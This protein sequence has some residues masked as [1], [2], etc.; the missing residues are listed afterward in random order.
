MSSSEL[1][2]AFQLTT[3]REGAESVAG[4]V[5][6]VLAER[7]ALVDA[8][9]R[10]GARSERALA[11]A[12]ILRMLVERARRS[13][14][15]GG[16]RS[17]I[18]VASELANIL[19]FEGPPSAFVKALTPFHVELLRPQAEFD[20]ALVEVL[21]LVLDGAPQGDGA[22]VRARLESLASPTAWSVKSHRRNVPG[23]AVELMKK[24][25]LKVAEGSVAP[26]LERQ[27]RWNEAAIDVLVER[28]RTGKIGSL[29][30]LRSFEAPLP[31]ADASVWDGV[32]QGQ[33]RFNAHVAT[34]LGDA[35]SSEAPAYGEWLRRRR[36]ARRVALAGVSDG[37]PF[38]VV[39]LGGDD[40]R[41]TA[42]LRAQLYPRW[43]AGAEQGDWLVFVEAG[44]TLDELALAELAAGPCRT[45]A[46]V[47]Y[48]DEDVGGARPFFKPDFSYELLLARDYT[49]RLLAVRRDA[50]ERAG[51]IEGGPYALALR[52]AELGMRFHHVA[53]VLCSRSPERVPGP[54]TAA[55]EEHLRR[56]GVKAFVE[57]RGAGH[58]VR[59]AVPSEPMVS[60]I[61]PFRDRPEL[62]EMLTRTLFA[63][64]RYR[65][66]ELLLVSN[67]SREPKTRE[68]LDR[69]DDPRVVKLE[70]N[71]PFHYPR[72]NNWAAKRAKGELLLFLNNDI[73]ITDP[74]WLTTLVGHA[75]QPGVGAVAPK[76]L[77]PDGTIQHAGV[78][79]GMTGFAGHVF[80]AQPD[81]GRET[82]FGSA[83]HARDCLAVTSAAVLLRRSLFDE[84]E[85]FD[86]RFTVC[87]GDVDLCLRAH[88]RGVRTVYQPAAVLV[89]HESV[90]RRGSKIPEDDFWESFRSYAPY[91][92]RDPFYSPHLG[93][94][95]TAPQLRADDTPAALDLALET[96]AGFEL[97]RGTR[98][99]GGR[100]TWARWGQDMVRK[101]DLSEEQ[102][103]AAG[104]HQ[105]LAH[106]PKSVTWLLPYFDHAFGGVHTILRFADV[107]RRKHGVENHFVIFDYP[108]VTPR[109]M[110]AKIRGLFDPLPGRFSILKSLNDI[111][112]LDACDVSIATLWSSAFYV[113]RHQQAR[114]RA[115]FVQDHEAQ[116]YPAGSMSGLAEQSYRLGL[117]GLF[118][119]R[120]L[121]EHVTAT[122]GMEGTWFDPTV[123]HALFHARGRT[124]GQAPLRLFFYGRP[125]ID[126]NAFELGLE[127]LRAVKQRLG[128]RVQI[129][130]AGE[131]WKPEWFDAEGIVENLGVLPYRQT[132][133]LY[134][135]ID[136]GLCFMFTRHPSYLPL[137][138]M[139]SGVAV[140]TNDNAAN[141][142]LLEHEQNCLLAPP[143]ASAV[144]QQV[145][146]ALVDRALR[147]RLGAAAAQR[148][149]TGDWEAEASKTYEALAR[150]CCTFVLTSVR[151]SGTDP[152]C[153]SAH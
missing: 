138:L 50:L 46:E 51:G 42:S 2:H 44:D 28:A 86:E 73:E 67:Q 43:K 16:A 122:Y 35:R 40:A 88:E 45:G 106:P 97:T 10:F 87:G 116:F 78:V 53:E 137:E 128:D 21:R 153:P 119:S 11:H 144:A 47:V 101:L 135:S 20:K 150:F 131:A 115:Y 96:L 54:Q 141:R 49:S 36:E 147:E 80:A 130:S 62:L 85:G 22:W 39:V 7:E 143:I 76:L 3:D 152:P 5:Q 9:R 107:W 33:A 18:E 81:D 134:R 121:Y 108:H 113:A 125:T 57:P 94:G 123:D 64:T 66:F 84:L 103:R 13:E 31:S 120:G 127:A 24:S 149:S 72:L 136:V 75:L 19:R 114:V 61:V 145:E 117:W 132:A 27:R 89:H 105:R 1:G 26:I 100:L 34:L 83:D 126:R 52:C 98:I 14:L 95:S 90:S 102:V 8:R 56:R 60:I 25:Y 65:N 37:P 6:L 23:R 146:R 69:L 111:E 74:D 124:A 12:A 63:K 140:V 71:H 118:N 70:W 104:R 68:V 110:E 82:L 99:S 92:E 55:V 93:L 30:T 109:E 142:W 58:A 17:P 29:E 59:Y 48:S 91:L 148:L 151:P 15:H 129:V 79:V 38:G 4:L 32:M 77:Y 112:T 139:A 41:T 133:E